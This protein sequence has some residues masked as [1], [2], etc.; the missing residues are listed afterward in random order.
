V[1]GQKVGKRIKRTGVKAEHGTGFGIVCKRQPRR[2]S[3]V[4]KT[5]QEGK[6]REGVLTTV[7]GGSK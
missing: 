6:G 2:A 4:M 7:K 3:S 1:L 5:L